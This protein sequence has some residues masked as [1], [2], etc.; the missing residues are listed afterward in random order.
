MRVKIL[1][2]RAGDNVNYDAGQV[3]DL[4]DARAERWI[5]AGFAVA[6]DESA[7]VVEPVVADEPKRGRRR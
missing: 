2:S 1:H 5:S 4:P 7:A 6:A 3:Y